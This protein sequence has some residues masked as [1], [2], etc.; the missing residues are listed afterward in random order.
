MRK[1]R[2]RLPKLCSRQRAVALCYVPP[3]DHDASA[4]A[5]GW[6]EPQSISVA[7]E[8]IHKPR[9]SSK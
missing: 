6:S 2:T 1:S 9:K 5:S 7:A 3:G 8:S 4:K